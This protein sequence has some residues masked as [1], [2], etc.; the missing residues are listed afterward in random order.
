MKFVYFP[1]FLWRFYQQRIPVEPGC[2][3]AS[4]GQNGGIIHE[5]P[6]I[7]V[8]KKKTFSEAFFA[9]TWYNILP[10]FIPV[11]EMYIYRC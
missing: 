3:W 7:S 1:S 8:K 11:K 9:L 10:Y 2:S 5:Y 6:G 4:A